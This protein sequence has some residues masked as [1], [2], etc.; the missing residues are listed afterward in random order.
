LAVD[1]FFLA[2]SLGKSI[3][4]VMLPALPV[5]G[6]EVVYSEALIQWVVCL[7]RSLKLMSKVRTE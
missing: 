7:S 1:T 5:L 6:S 3:S 4:I 2:Q